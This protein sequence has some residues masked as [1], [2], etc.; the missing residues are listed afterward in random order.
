MSVR[1]G[2]W[3]Q[4]VE[5]QSSRQ[6]RTRV[7]TELTAGLS[8]CVADWVKIHVELIAIN[9]LLVRCSIILVWAEQVW[10][11]LSDTKQGKCWSA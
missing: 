2:V 5:A 8:A 7:D 6:A 9:F 4:D 3:A 1:I 10:S 11:P